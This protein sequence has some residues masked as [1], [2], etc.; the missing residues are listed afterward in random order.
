MA[1]SLPLL[2]PHRLSLKAGL[3]RSE[4][5][6]A[7]GTAPELPGKH[8][9]PGE[10]PGLPLN[11]SDQM[12]TGSEGTSGTL[13]L[14]TRLVEEA[15]RHLLQKMRRRLRSRRGGE[16]KTEEDA[17]SR[18]P[19]GLQ[20]QTTQRPSR[21]SRV[22]HWSQTPRN[23]VRAQGKHHATEPGPRGS[24]WLLGP[25][26]CRL[27]TRSSQTDAEN[28]T[29]ALHWPLSGAR[30]THTQ[31]TTC[32]AANQVSISE[33]GGDTVSSTPSCAEVDGEAMRRVR[34]ERGF[35]K[36]DRVEQL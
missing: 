7:L 33:K 13:W 5:R 10:R 35:R 14:P 25:E 26:G 24:P 3:T 8:I 11:P 31:Q 4:G 12:D 19:E 9:C 34:R 6:H 16:E 21:T 22:R 29:E 15:E 2:P 20:H 32:Q 18:Q 27:Q 36:T 28:L 30:G 23:E 17:P 1:V